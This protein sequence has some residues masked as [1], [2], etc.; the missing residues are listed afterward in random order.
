M[1]DIPRIMKR[2]WQK[3][4]WYLPRAIV[5]LILYFIPG[6]GQT[7]APVL[8]F[9]FSAWMLAIQYCDTRSIT[10]RCRLKRCATPCAP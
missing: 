5:L 3:L 1:K 10:T 4:A 8:W 9:L 2:E 7:V 6:I